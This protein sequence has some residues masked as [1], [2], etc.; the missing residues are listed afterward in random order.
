[1]VINLKTYRENKEVIK[2]FKILNDFFKYQFPE[3]SWGWIG[4]TA[5]LYSQIALENY[6]GAEKV[7]P[8]FKPALKAILWQYL[9]VV[10]NKKLGKDDRHE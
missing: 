9:N 4:I 10:A 2:S 8:E 7:K 1:M 6:L 3:K 5:L